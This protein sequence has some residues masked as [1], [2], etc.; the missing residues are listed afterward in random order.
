MAA[1]TRTPAAAAADASNY[2]KTADVNLLRN[3]FGLLFG[4]NL[5]LFPCKV[6]VSTFYSLNIIKTHTTAC[7]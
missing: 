6:H 7:C 5:K 4:Y 3:F 1:A 2:R